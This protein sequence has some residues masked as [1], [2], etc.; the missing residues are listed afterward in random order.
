LVLAGSD[1]ERRYLRYRGESAF[2]FLRA[3]NRLQDALKFDA[4]FD[5]EPAAA[6]PA[7]APPA[8]E[9]VFPDHPTTFGDPPVVPVV[10]PE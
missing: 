1:E 4:E 9:V 7:A 3:Q 10:T 5:R 2:A 8:G 6:G